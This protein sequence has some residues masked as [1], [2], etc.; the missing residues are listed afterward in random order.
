[1]AAIKALH[2]IL[3]ASAG[4]FSAKI[5]KM[6]MAAARKILEL[7]SKDSGHGNVIRFWID[8]VNRLAPHLGNQQKF[9]LE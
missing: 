8:E 6:I 5:K 1:M 2:N 3:I 7:R 9:A 4:C